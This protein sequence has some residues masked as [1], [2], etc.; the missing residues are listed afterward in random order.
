MQDGSLIRGL[1]AGGYRGQDIPNGTV[2]ENPEGKW[3]E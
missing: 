1:S 3:G 2:P